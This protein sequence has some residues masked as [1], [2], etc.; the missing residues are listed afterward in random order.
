MKRI[1]TSEARRNG[2]TITSAP[3][4]LTHEASAPKPQRRALAFTLATIQRDAYRAAWQA[5]FLV[6]GGKLLSR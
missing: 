2:R 6:D 5:A 4:Q 3:N 1:S